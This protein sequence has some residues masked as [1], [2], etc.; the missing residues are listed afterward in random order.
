M[1]SSTPIRYISSGTTPLYDEQS[2]KRARIGS[3]P[4]SPYSGHPQRLLSSASRSPT[5]SSSSIPL[6]SI[7]KLPL[8]EVPSSSTSLVTSRTS[9]QVSVRST[10][11]WGLVCAC[12]INRSMTAHDNLLR[13]GYPSSL[14]RSY[15]SW[16]SV[17]LPAYIGGAIAFDFGT[18][19]E[20]MC[21]T[22]NQSGPGA[23]QWM[24]ETGMQAMLERD[25][26]VKSSPDRWQDLPVATT[27]PKQDT[28]YS[29]DIVVC[30]DSQVYRL[31][32]E[33]LHA[34]GLVPVG[35]PFNHFESVYQ[36]PHAPRKEGVR[37]I[38]LVLLHTRDTIEDAR[39]AGRNSV[40]FAEAL[41]PAVARALESEDAL[42]SKGGF[43]RSSL[44]NE[45]TF[46]VGGVGFPVMQTTDILVSG[47]DDESESGLTTV[48]PLKAP[49]T[50]RT[51]V[52]DNEAEGTKTRRM[53][54][55]IAALTRKA[56][57]DLGSRL[58]LTDGSIHHTEF[59]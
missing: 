17:R 27:S 58:Q 41:C 47:G 24:K 18:P 51:S 26:S 45:S 23:S 29:H 37:S 57:L 11:S 20:Y 49:T 35:N 55:N 4:G 32:A 59:Q 16:D 52:G 13:A 44:K 40:E 38:Q 15:G 19:Y 39:S 5:S 56:L 34:K 14:L 50:S 12:N 46:A 10:L 7:S 22:L 43:V 1:S 31:V 54:K 36:V 9:T 48:T 21:S 6:L 53:P 30:F 2:V 33:D 8:T 25:A 28:I 3:T 42:E